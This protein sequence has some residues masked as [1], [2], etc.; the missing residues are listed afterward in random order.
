MLGPTRVP[1]YVAFVGTTEFAEGEWIGVALDEAVGKNDGSVKGIK[2]FECRPAHG[3]FVRARQVE[4][5][6]DPAVAPAVM[7][8]ARASKVR[9]SELP[10][11]VLLKAHE[12]K[13]ASQLPSPAQPKSS[14]PPAGLAEKATGVQKAADVP[15]LPAPS[16]VEPKGVMEPLKAAESAK[17]PALPK[18][19]ESPE[20]GEPPKVVELPPPKAAAS[21]S[22]LAGSGGSVPSAS[23]EGTDQKRAKVQ[24]DLAAAVEEHNDAAIRKLLPVAYDCGVSHA[25]IE[26]AHGVLNFRLQ[27]S[28]L[29]EIDQVREAVSGLADSVRVMQGRVQEDT[30]AREVPTPPGAVS[31]P[32]CAE[33]C[34]P[35]SDPVP[36]A[37]PAKV[38][39]ELG[40]EAIDRFV[41][42]VEE[43]LERHLERQLVPL[44]ERRVAD[45]VQQLVVGATQ[46]I[47]AVALDATLRARDL[48]WQRALREPD[49]R[50]LVLDGAG[51]NGPLRPT[52]AEEER[53][54]D[55]RTQALS[56]G[57]MSSEE[58]QRQHDAACT[59]QR[60]V[61][62]KGAAGV[63]RK[64]V[65]VHAEQRHA[66]W[67]AVYDR[68]ATC[69]GPS[70]DRE[71]FCRA[72]RRIHPRMSYGQASAFWNNH[73]S[74]TEQPTMDLETFMRIAEAVAQG[75]DEAAEF[76]DLCLETFQMLGH[77]NAD[78]AATKVQ[79]FYRGRGVRTA[80]PPTA[81]AARGSA[82]A[83]ARPVAPPADAAN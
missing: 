7:A 26:N 50:E 41:A 44:L 47:R 38:S 68:S 28:L 19:A 77:E 74:S 60:R 36:G 72:L 39:E 75:D 22:Q 37:K 2:Y 15:R 49:A 59:I 65:R 82:A 48:D 76:A 81:C 64:S 58:M 53:A 61:R 29:K 6:Q 9:A 45:A 16:A 46:E 57:R 35:A 34:K 14:E 69:D 40:Q 4:R 56:H 3:L 30:A 51:Q 20:A 62:A 33:P 17:E 32:A 43:Q 66:D 13:A 18:T 10:K 67:L 79:A 24:R 1:G 63:H 11:A 54:A 52:P 25:C 78:A 42:H 12:P 70:L 71:A 80:G 21:S 73:R 55:L 83:A 5:V 31:E 8:S 23:L 27:Q